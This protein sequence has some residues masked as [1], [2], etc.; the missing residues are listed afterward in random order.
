MR[1]LVLGCGSIGSRHARNLHR[2]G[3]TDLLLFD[4]DRDRVRALAAQIGGAQALAE[5]AQVYAQNP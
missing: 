5:T 3:I 1:I 2:L 4:P